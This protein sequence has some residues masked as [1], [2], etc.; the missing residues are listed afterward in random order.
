LPPGARLRRRAAPDRPPVL[1]ELGIAGLHR[2]GGRRR[3]RRSRG[4]HPRPVPLAPMIRRA[5]LAAAVLGT[6]CARDDGG[7]R[8]LIRVSTPAAGGTVTSPIR[9]T[10]EARGTWYFEGSFPVR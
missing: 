4:G 9:V 5:L 3:P 8:D 1:R 2:R 10:G 6:G 7:T